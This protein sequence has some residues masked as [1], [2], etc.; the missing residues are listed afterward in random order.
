MDLRAGAFSGGHE[1]G[2]AQA[3]GAG[4]LQGAEDRFGVDVSGDAPPHRLLTR[5]FQQLLEPLVQ[6]YFAAV[7][8]DIDPVGRSAYA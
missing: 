8:G 3:G 7:D 1:L 5:A 4:L 2:D 6:V